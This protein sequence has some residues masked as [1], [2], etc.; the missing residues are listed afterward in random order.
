MQQHGGRIDASSEPGEYSEFKLFFPRRE[1]NALE[2][3][4]A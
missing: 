3:T 1:E 4:R 2:L